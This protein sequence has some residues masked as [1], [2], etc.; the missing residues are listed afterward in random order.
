[1]IFNAQELSTQ[2]YLFNLYQW[3]IWSFIV[4]LPH[5]LLLMFDF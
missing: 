3:I 1:M 5:F 4:R 2:L